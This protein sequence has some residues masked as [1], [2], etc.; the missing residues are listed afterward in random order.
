MDTKGYLESCESDGYSSDSNSF[1]SPTIFDNNLQM[2]KKEK[3]S[4]AFSVSDGLSRTEMNLRRS[5]KYDPRSKFVSGTTISE[6]L[7]TK[8]DRKFS[9]KSSY[10]STDLIHNAPKLA[11]DDSNSNINLNTNSRSPISVGLGDGTGNITR[12]LRPRQHMDK[13]SE[14]CFE[15]TI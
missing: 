14:L 7:L 2:K 8:Q 13:L 9:G 6:Y 11:T 5:D 3:M 10:A 4:E 1:N 12:N 15:M